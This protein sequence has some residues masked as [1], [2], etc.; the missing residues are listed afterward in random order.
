MEQEGS[1]TKPYKS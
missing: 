1:K